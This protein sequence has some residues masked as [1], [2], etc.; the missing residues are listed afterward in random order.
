MK[1]NSQFRQWLDIARGA[2][3]VNKYTI[4]LFVFLVWMLFFDKHNMIVQWQLHHKANVLREQIET[5]NEKLAAARQE[6]EILQTQEERY[7]REKYRMHKPDEE[8]F[9]IA[10]D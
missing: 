4:A 8:V 6:L 5:E 7:A 10:Q 9:V 1:T 2:G 3:W